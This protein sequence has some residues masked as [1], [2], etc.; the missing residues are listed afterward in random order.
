MIMG[1]FKQ[2]QIHPRKW[3]IP[4]KNMGRNKTWILITELEIRQKF[5]IWISI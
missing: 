2:N 5:R 1:A 4:L 3:P